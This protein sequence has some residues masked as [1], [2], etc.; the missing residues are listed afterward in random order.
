MVALAWKVL[1]NSNTRRPKFLA[2]SIF[3]DDQKKAE[4]TEG[5]VNFY[6]LFR[7]VINLI[8]CSLYVY[9]TYRFTVTPIVSILNRVFASCFALEI[10]FG[11]LYSPS[12]T[13]Y[14]L[15]LH[16]FLSVCSIP[17]LFVASGPKSF[18]HYGF[19][20]ALPAHDSFKALERRFVRNRTDPKQIFIR[21]F[22][23]FLTLFY[24]L[25]AGIQML[26]IPG[27]WLKE[28]FL[29]TWGAVGDWTFFNCLYYV[30]V[31]LST[32]GYGDF[33]PNTIQGRIYTIFMIIV[34]IIVFS[35]IVEE[36]KNDTKRQRGVGRYSRNK[37]KRHVIVLGT[38][39]IAEFRHF[40]K[41]FYWGDSSYLNKNSIVVVMVE[42]PKWDDE[43][44]YSEIAHNPYLQSHIIYLK[45]SVKDPADLDRAGIYTANAVFILTS[46]SL[47]DTLEFSG[48]PDGSRRVQQA[49]TQTVMY[50][51]AVRNVR[52][53]IPIFAL[54][55][56]NDSNIQIEFA[57]GREANKNLIFRPSADHASQF[58]HF[59]T[60]VFEEEQRYLVKDV[61]DRR[62]ISHMDLPEAPECDEVASIDLERSNHVCLQQLYS[63]MMV[64]NINANGVSTLVTNLHIEFDD[65]YNYYY[66]DIKQ[67]WLVEYNMGAETSLLNAIIPKTLH[68]LRIRDVAPIL[69]R[70]GLVVVG[71]RGKK[72]IEPK[73]LL[74]LNRDDAVFKGGDICL[75]LT[76]LHMQ[77][78]GYALD[79][80]ATEIKDSGIQKTPDLP[81]LKAVSSKT[82]MNSR[83]ETSNEENEESNPETLHFDSVTE[84]VRDVQSGRNEISS[85]KDHLIIAV[86]GG[87]PLDQVIYFL[88]NLKLTNQDT[89]Q[90]V[91]I[92]PS[93][94]AE[95]RSKFRK[96]RPRIQFHFVD[97]KPAAQ[98]SWKEANIGSAKAVATLADY[99]I[100]RDN[101]DAQTIYTLLALD[102]ISLIN[103][104]LFICSELI[105]E[106]SIEL[107]RQP[108][109]SRRRG[110]KL[111]FDSV[112][113]GTDAKD[114]GNHETEVKTKRLQ[115]DSLFQ[116]HRYASGELLV[117]S[118]ADSLLVREYA[119]PGF[120]HFILDLFGARSTDGQK[121][122]LINVPSVVFEHESAEIVERKRYVEY[123]V[124]FDMLVNAG[125]TPLGLYR[126]GDAKIKR[127]KCKRWKRGTE[128]QNKSIGRSA[129]F[130]WLDFK[131]KRMSKILENVEAARP[132]N[133]K[134][135]Q[136]GR[137]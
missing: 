92:F 137:P 131:S 42:S 78:I 33:S 55:L 87:T 52:T 70:N 88:D 60:T 81:H 74:D 76:Y 54:T 80:V 94:T 119:E 22:V 31:T 124:L 10:I 40:V 105:D 77:H 28:E 32:V 59:Y 102:S 44:W 123:G 79:V 51:L 132:N 96:F 49:D 36:L 5:I 100:D 53:D 38:P 73:M 39:T 109:F 24:V 108:I 85:W 62:N 125:V 115:R 58:K 37:D 23:Q 46:P 127:N 106:Q 34:G 90:V 121:I 98:S 1:R 4:Q 136:G 26:E 2:L 130:G 29:E 99:T 101:S 112:S 19:L 41:E 11:I 21:L 67:N 20:R 129:T 111:G 57:M 82:E 83:N 126:S 122:Q 3:F 128:L 45:G 50:S 116:R 110:L 43:T 113:E 66:T 25:A 97:G 12:A 114:S 68:N 75:F 91:I 18:L 63:A 72:D 133:Q 16:R 120:I 15:N 30:T 86:E 95:D 118:T 71:T 65:K 117:H 104:D 84:T 8:V 14:V 35:N 61:L 48:D 9:T 93:H 7:V 64:A 134:F 69:F 17:S 56:L 27:D 135:E 13:T 6:H 103:T 47:G 107:L 89:I